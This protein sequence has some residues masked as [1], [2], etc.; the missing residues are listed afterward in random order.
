MQSQLTYT[1]PAEF[2]HHLPALQQLLNAAEH[3]FR[4]Q[5]RH[6]QSSNLRRQLTLLQQLHQHTVLLL[7]AAPEAAAPQDSRIVALRQFYLATEQEINSPAA[8]AQLRLQLNKQLQWQK[9]LLRSQQLGP[10][11]TVLL[12]FTASLQMAADQLALRLHH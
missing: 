9:K 5:A 1:S 12:H 6:N 11:H 3:Y 4:H 10:C 7:P 2:P 8:L